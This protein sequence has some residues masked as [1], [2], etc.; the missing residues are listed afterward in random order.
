MALW[1]PGSLDGFV[2]PMAEVR[3]SAKRPTAWVKV[4]TFDERA[5]QAK[6]RDTSEEFAASLEAM[7]KAHRFSRR[8]G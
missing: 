5:E 4:D 3:M 6:P 8:T 1:R 7:F 2:S